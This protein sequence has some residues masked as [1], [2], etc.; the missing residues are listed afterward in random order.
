MDVF[1][2]RTGKQISLPDAEGNCFP[3]T[4]TLMLMLQTLSYE[5]TEVKKVTLVKDNL[6]PLAV[7]KP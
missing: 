5:A 6:Q 1:M 2:I 4:K 3:P 7:I